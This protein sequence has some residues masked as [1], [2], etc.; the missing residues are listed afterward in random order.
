MLKRILVVLAALVFIL[1]MNTPAWASEAQIVNNSNYVNIV[2]PISRPN[3]ASGIFMSI[4]T[5][6]RRDGTPADGNIIVSAPGLKFTPI[7]PYI[8]EKDI[9]NFGGLS[10]AWG[11]PH[12]T[13]G[14]IKS[15]YE[16]RAY[17]LKPLLPKDSVVYYSNPGYVISYECY[18]VKPNKPGR[19][20][21]SVSIDGKVTTIPVTFEQAPIGV[22]YKPVI[23]YSPLTI[24]WTNNSKTPLTYNKNLVFTTPPSGDLSGYITGWAKMYSTGDFTLSNPGM[25]TLSPTNWKVSSN[26]TVKDSMPIGTMTGELEMIFSSHNYGKKPTGGLTEEIA[27]PLS[28]NLSLSVVGPFSATFPLTTAAGKIATGVVIAAAAAAL[29][30]KKWLPLIPLFRAVSVAISL[31]A[32]KTGAA[33]LFFDQKKGPKKVVVDVTDNTGKVVI[34]AV[35]VTKGET[36]EVSLPTLGKTVLTAKVRK[37]RNTSKQ[38]STEYDPFV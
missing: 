35:H 2:Y 38:K 19:Y 6:I 17:Y 37:Y 25:H 10:S 29:T 33:S 27:F 24:L 4:N 16:N 1:G 5:D 14:E 15:G 23:T 34:T 26:I 7:T 13:P 11:G 36:A 20:D 21:I 8:G 22:S 18:W 9:K 31:E 28:P 12:Y 3:V 32:T 30:R